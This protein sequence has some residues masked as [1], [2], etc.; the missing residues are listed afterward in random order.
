MNEELYVTPDD[1][2]PFQAMEDAYGQHP[3]CPVEVL[4]DGSQVWRVPPGAEVELLL[5][6]GHRQ[7]AVLLPDAHTAQSELV[8]TRHPDAPNTTAVQWW[9]HWRALR[10]LGYTQPEP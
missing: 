1:L 7:R 8:A 9:V 2:V 3:E 5:R 4:A 10:R 6:A